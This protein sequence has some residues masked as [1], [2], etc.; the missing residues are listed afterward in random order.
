MHL[1][2]KKQKELSF[3]W[4]IYI[5]LLYRRINRILWRHEWMTQNFLFQS[6]SFLQFEEISEEKLLRGMIQFR[7]IFL[8]LFFMSLGLENLFSFSCF[9]LTKFK[10]LISKKY[11]LAN[12]FFLPCFRWL[13]ISIHFFYFPILKLNIN[14]DKVVLS[15]ILYSWLISYRI[16]LFFKLYMKSF[17]QNIFFVKIF[18][19]FM[20]SWY[21]LFLI[22]H[23]WF[24][25]CLKVG[26]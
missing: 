19:Y 16:T 2:N 25:W 26:Q 10:L 14:Y 6:N 7:V 15:F 20:L 13:I 12:F 22:Y 11:I 17:S 1:F 4:S 18:L 3:L 5:V 9:L 21:S 24:S 23:L 8:S